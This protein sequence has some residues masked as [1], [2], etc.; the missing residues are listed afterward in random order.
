[1]GRGL[2]YFGMSEESGA[3]KGLIE[4][5]KLES[6]I[7]MENLSLDEQSNAQHKQMSAELSM[8]GGAAGYVG[9]AAAG[10]AMGA[11]YGAWGGPVG[12]VAGAALGFL[13]SKLF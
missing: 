8:A 9:G 6:E 5:D 13:A 10:A 7:G 2:L 3:T 11:A 12:M 4:S 1:M